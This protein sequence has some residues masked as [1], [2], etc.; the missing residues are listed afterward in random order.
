M[1]RIFTGTANNGWGGQDVLFGG[2]GVDTFMF[3]TN[4]QYQTPAQADRVMDFI[5]GED[6]LDFRSFDADLSIAGMQGFTFIGDAD[7]NT[8]FLP[9]Y[10]LRFENGRVEGNLDYDADADFVIELT[11]VS[12]LSTSD[13]LLV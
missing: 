8:G 9:P 2:D 7:F 1:V 10:Q 12:F 13:F 6:K 11:G 5:S 3:S 4:Y